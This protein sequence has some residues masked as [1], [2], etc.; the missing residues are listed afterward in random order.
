MNIPVRVSSLTRLVSF[1]LSHNRFSGEIPESLEQMQSLI[2]F[3]VSYNQQLIGTLP[4]FCKATVININKTFVSVPLERVTFA[5]RE[6]ISKANLIAVFVGVLTIAIGITWLTHNY[7][8]LKYMHETAE[9]QESSILQ[10][11][12]MD[13]QSIHRENIDFEKALKATL[14]PANVI[15]SPDNQFAYILQGCDALYNCLHYEGIQLD[16]G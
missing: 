5:A 4:H 2:E 16:D 15:L 13:P 14:D 8:C 7:K 12:L 11:H 9:K 10:C 6:H 3:D 1:D